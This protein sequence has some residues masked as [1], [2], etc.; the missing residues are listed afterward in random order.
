MSTKSKVDIEFYEI[1]RDWLGDE[2]LTGYV[3]D[4][5]SVRR[6]GMYR[7]PLFEL[8]NKSAANEMTQVFD[9]I[10]ERIG[11]PKLGRV[12]RPAKQKDGK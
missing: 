5:A 11:Q 12:C 3:S 8:P 4:R 9:E 10:M 1:L 7:I 6:A 2:L